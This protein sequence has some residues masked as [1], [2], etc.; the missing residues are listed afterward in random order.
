SSTAPSRASPGGA[1]YTFTPVRKMYCSE[2]PFDTVR[3]GTSSTKTMSQ[4]SLVS[5]APACTPTRTTRELCGSMRTERGETLS[6]APHD[7][8]LEPAGRNRLSPF[9]AR[10]QSEREMVAWTGLSV[11][12]VSEKLDATRLEPWARI[13]TSSG[14]TSSCAEPRCENPTHT[15]QRAR[16]VA[17]ARPL[18]SALAL[19]GERE[20]ERC[21]SYGAVRV[22]TIG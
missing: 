9:S 16:T 1:T 11:V 17:R 6:M 13:V 21:I 10:S 15:A 2:L 5:A 12:F 8:P 20:P 4:H 18:R 7:I 3:C 19:L 22:N 14:S